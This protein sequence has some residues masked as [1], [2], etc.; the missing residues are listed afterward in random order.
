MIRTNQRTYR[1]A[2]TPD[3][4]ATFNSQFGGV[5]RSSSS[6]ETLQQNP[7]RLR[8]GIGLIRPMGVA[9]PVPLGQGNPLI[10]VAD[11]RRTVR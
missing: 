11:I 4:T 2:M 1:E 7:Q 10:D 6:L 5:W 3:E 8:S 9:R